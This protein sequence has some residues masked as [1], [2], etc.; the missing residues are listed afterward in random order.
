MYVLMVVALIFSC[1]EETE[2]HTGPEREMQWIVTIHSICYYLGGDNTYYCVS[3]ET[4]NKLKDTLND[5]MHSYC[6][7][8][9]FKTTKGNTI[10]GY[11]GGVIASGGACDDIAEDV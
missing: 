6:D 3:E 4:Y 10:S 2:R 7:P 8:V 1:S 5:P 11:L 9:T